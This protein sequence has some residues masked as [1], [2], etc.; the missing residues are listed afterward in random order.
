MSID[1]PAGSEK[2]AH[3]PQIFIGEWLKGNVN[4]AQLSKWSDDPMAGPWL[5]DV[6]QKAV[7]IL[8]GLSPEKLRA[9]SGNVKPLSGEY[10][11][12]E[13]TLKYI[14]RLI[15]TPERE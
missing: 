15:S 12:V 6:K 8:S 9:E 5:L 1:F 13:E 14:V 2:Y 3:N 11:T 7:D 10:Y 4:P